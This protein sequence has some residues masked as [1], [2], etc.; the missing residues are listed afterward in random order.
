M[1][2]PFTSHFSLF[3]FPRCGRVEKNLS[4]YLDRE[5][6]LRTAKKLEAHLSGCPRCREKLAALERVENALAAFPGR[7]PS[8]FLWTRVKAGVDSGAEP[9]GSRSLP[10]LARFRM[11]P[12][13]A[14]VAVVSLFLAVV[15]GGVIFSLRK[16]AV[17]PP[18]RADGS[19]RPGETA[20]FEIAVAENLDLLEN[21]ELIK[22]LDL[23]ENWEGKS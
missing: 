10:I 7:E 5:L 3:T 21:Y 17:R 14:R 23:L 18:A 15:L 2:K 9:A 1:K 20:G 4:A 16:G 13:P 6:D 11:A 19:C 12:V 8:P 22:N